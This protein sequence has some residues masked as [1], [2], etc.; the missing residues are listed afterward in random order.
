M[1]D[2][3]SAAR[4]ENAS[5]PLL[6]SWR[7]GEMGWYD[8]LLFIVLLIPAL[9]IL[10]L[11]NRRRERR[12]KQWLEDLRAGKLPPVSLENARNGTISIEATGFTVASPWRKDSTATVEWAQIEEIRAFK[13]DL[14]TTDRIC[15]GFCRPGDDLMVVAS[16]DMVGFKELQRTVESRFGVKEEDWWRRVAFP[17][18]ARNMTVI[19]PKDK[20]TPVSG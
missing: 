13:Q 18:F 8:L 17:A 3:D 2:G 7:Q 10:R 4:V 19:W 16:E 14:F 11:R 1:N 15:W 6:Y 9:A 5:G 12:H 20:E